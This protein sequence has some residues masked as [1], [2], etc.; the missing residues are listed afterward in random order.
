MII[1]K[2]GRE[3]RESLEKLK[4]WARKIKIEYIELDS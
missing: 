4:I 2:A 1:E 3:L